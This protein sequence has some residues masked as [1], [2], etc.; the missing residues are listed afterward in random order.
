M[1]RVNGATNAL[2]IGPSAGYLL[3]FVLVHILFS[4]I[5]NASSDTHMHIHAITYIT[6]FF[7]I[8]LKLIVPNFLTA[9]GKILEVPCNLV[10]FISTF[11]RLHKS[12]KVDT[13]QILFE[14]I[15]NMDRIGSISFYSP[16]SG[17]RRHT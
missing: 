1:S 13:L 12:L 2:S 9:Y 14:Y 4:F 17:E 7:Y 5:S 3:F 8:K 15:M 16:E 10:V 11:G 6:L